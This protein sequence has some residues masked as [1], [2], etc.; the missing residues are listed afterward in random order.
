MTKQEFLISLRKGLSGLHTDDIESR[1][2][3]YAEI[4]DDKTEEGISEES[5]VSQI[6]SVDEIIAQIIAETPFVKIV[7]EKIKPKRRF[8]A[9]EL[10]FL[11]LGSP[12]WVSLLVSIF[13]VI[14]SVYISLWAVIISLW[15]VFVSLIGCAIGGAAASILLFYQ[16]NAMG[17]V[18]VAGAA[19]VL[20]GLAIFSFMGCKAATKGILL[21]TKNFA[22][23]LKK[24]FIKKEGAQ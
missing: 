14:L 22:I 17:G 8:S 4:I 18:A 9:W 13:A 1:L 15:A 5:A 7:K 16:G 20:F 19:L 24:R 3:F 21:L 6:G 23:W 10:L 2:D 12:I 11:I